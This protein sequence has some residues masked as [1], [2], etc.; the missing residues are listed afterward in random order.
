MRPLVRSKPMNGFDVAGTAARLSERGGGYEV[1]HTSPGLEIGVYVLVAPE[2][3]QQVP[4]A[5]DEIYV[6]LDGAGEVE[7]NGRRRPVT[8]GEGVFVAAGVDHRFHAYEE[9]S[10]LVVFSGPQSAVR[11][12]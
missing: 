2:A 12:D 11:S 5:F 1:V 10:L 6:V 4:H 9:L 7:V 8:R 3:D